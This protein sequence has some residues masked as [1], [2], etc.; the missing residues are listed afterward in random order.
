[1]RPALRRSCPS[2]R[3]RRP[4]SIGISQAKDDLVIAFL[5]YRDRSFFEYLDSPAPAED[6]HE[7]LGQNRTGSKSSRHR[8]LPVPSDRIRIPGLGTPVSSRGDRTR[9][10]VSWLPNRSVKALRH[11]Q[12]GG[13]RGV[14]QRHRWRPRH[15][16]AQ[17]DFEEI[18]I[19]SMF[20]IGACILRYRR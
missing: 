20:G 17:W 1:M 15:E 14:A 8:R 12:K 13:G 18:P 5:E 6:I 19:L 7:A 4:P 10:H 2:P 16:N 3:S 11:R 9:K